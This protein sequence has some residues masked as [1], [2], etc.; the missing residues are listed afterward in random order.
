MQDLLADRPFTELAAADI[1]GRAG[2]PIESFHECFDDERAALYELLDQMYRRAESIVWTFCDPVRWRGQLLTEFVTENVRLNVAAYGRS[3][4]LYR[5]ALGASAVDERFRHRR[6]QI[7]LTCAAAQKGFILSRRD[8]VGRTDPD[9]ASDEFFELMVA[10]LDEE[11]LLGRF[12]T[13]APASPIELTSH[14]A[15]QAMRT[16]GLRPQM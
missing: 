5:A 10:R 9:R 12:T 4:P 15:E 7:M 2:L 6:V 13:T 14:L 11:V 16:L 1:A 3:G 8:E